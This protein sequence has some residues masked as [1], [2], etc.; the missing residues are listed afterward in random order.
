MHDLIQSKKIFK[1]EELDEDLGSAEEVSAAT[2]AT[3]RQQNGRKQWLMEEVA[4]AA[5]FI[6]STEK[7]ITRS[8]RKVLLLLKLMVAITVL[9]W[10]S[11][12]QFLLMCQDVISSQV[13]NNHGSF[14]RSDYLFTETTKVDQQAAEEW[15]KLFS[16]LYKAVGQIFFPRCS[17]DSRQ[18][19]EK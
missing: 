16:N 1:D 12:Q 2:R 15:P 13:M 5:Q 3:N 8:S 14:E 9:G 17:V 18:E 10:I 6:E 4:T 11:N 7:P 19:T